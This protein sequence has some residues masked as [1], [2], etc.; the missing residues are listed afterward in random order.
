MPL[1]SSISGFENVAELWRK[2]YCDIF[3]CVKGD[4]FIVGDVP[5]ND[6]VVIR[7][8]EVCY[9]QKLS[10]NK[11]C[12]L[13][14]ITAEHLKYAAAYSVFIALCFTGLLMHGELPVSML[15]VVLVPVVKDKTGKISSLENYRPNALA[16]VLSKVLKQIIL[17][18]LQQYIISTDN[19]FGF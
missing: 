1:P 12:G 10:L 11:A 8:D 17:D 18:R 9:A 6:G 19:Q 4:V 3:N 5:Y 16:S 2:H 15:S 7:P 13:D 14:Q